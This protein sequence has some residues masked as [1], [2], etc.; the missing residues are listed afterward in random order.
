M[1]TVQVRGFLAITVVAVSM[2]VAAVLAI[3]PLFHDVM[4]KE[5]ADT[6]GKMVSPF[7]GLVGAVIGYYFGKHD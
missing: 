7:T 1:T 2:L 4:H 5:W 3:Y 6:F